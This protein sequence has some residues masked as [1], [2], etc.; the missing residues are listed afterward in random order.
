MSYKI[1]ILITALFC[2]I[3]EPLF[4]EGSED[5]FYSELSRRSSEVVSLN[6][7]F[8]QTKHVKLL[9]T[10]VVSQGKFYYKRGGAIRFDYSTPKIMS[11]IML[12][13]KLRIETQSK[14]TTYDFARQPSLAELAAIIEA[15]VSGN[16]KNLPDKYKVVY[17]L[18]PDCHVVTITNLKKTPDNPYT[19]IELHFDLD[20]YSLKELI[21]YER[22]ED[23]TYYSFNNIVANG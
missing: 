17:T 4:S 2:V 22:S 19:K 1:I 20:N 7:R 15:C 23:T 18:S 12:K 8:T 14:A 21:L 9:N 11:I 16:I 6:S 5:S 13:D 3:S 10:K